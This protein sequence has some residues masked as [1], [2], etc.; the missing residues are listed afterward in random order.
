MF[1][2]LKITF[3]MRTPVCLTYPFIHFDA[4]LAHLIQRKNDTIGYRS[5]PSKKVVTRYGDL[6]MP[7]MSQGNGKEYIFNASISFFDI[8]DA[9]STT[10][11]K[12]FCERY[13][14]LRRIKKKRIDRA[15]GHFKDYMINLVYIPA[16]KV[17]FYAMGNAEE[18]DELL[19]GLPGLG[20]KIAIGYGFIKSYEIEEIDHNYS[21]LK[22]GRAMRAIPV[23][24]LKSTSDVAQLAYKSPYWASENTAMCAPPG[25][26]V[27]LDLSAIGK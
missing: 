18:I 10:I 15:R 3:R 16:R 5:L 25:A 21:I 7:L 9:Y 13:L 22:D 2:P 27:K 20:K 23:S 17:T 4:I 11:Y 19:K 14:N 26:Y 6:T 24:F 12:R 1:T 8:K